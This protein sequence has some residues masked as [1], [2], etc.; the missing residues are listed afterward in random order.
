MTGRKVVFKEIHVNRAIKSVALVLG[1]GAI[2]QVSGAA[3]YAT[4]TGA[5]NGYWTNANNWVDGQ[6]GGRWLARDAGGNL[7][8]NGVLHFR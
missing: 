5:E 8:T 3:S 6:I 2:L 4:W 7:V 1:I